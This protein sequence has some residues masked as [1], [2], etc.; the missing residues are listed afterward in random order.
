MSKKKN[1]VRLTEEPQLI[2]S[3]AP[4]EYVEAFKELRTN[5]NFAASNKQGEK[6]CRKLVVTSSVPDEGKSTVVTNLAISLVQDGNRVL[7]VDADMRNPVLRKYLSLQ[8]EQPT[9][10]SALLNGDVKIG[11][12]LVRTT[13]GVDVIADGPIPPNPAELIK[14]DAMQSLIRG[15]EAYYDYIIFDTP[16]V[17]VITDAAALSS[18]CD[19]V[20]YVVRHKFASKACVHNAVRKLKMVD[21]KILGVV[22]MQYDV[23][24][25]SRNYGYYHRYRKYGK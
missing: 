12:C 3:D 1:A 6:K 5:L 11:E 13:F 2:S 25:A 23:P 21:A 7:V 17:G 4:F 9:G 18:L 19:G 16:P 20:V 14:S 22:L 24:K 10:L 15:S 8:Q